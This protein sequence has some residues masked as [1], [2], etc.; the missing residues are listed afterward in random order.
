MDELGLTLGEYLFILI[1]VLAASSVGVITRFYGTS[2]DRSMLIRLISW[3]S[4]YSVDSSYLS[5]Y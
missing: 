3:F 2:G 4:V 1:G 5:A